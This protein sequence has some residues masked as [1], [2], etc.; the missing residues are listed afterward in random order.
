MNLNRRSMLTRSSALMG[1]LAAG[2]ASRTSQTAAQENI[3]GAESWNQDQA[4]VLSPDRLI[5]V[6]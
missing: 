2:L 3:P 1:G 4:V 5:L 6:P